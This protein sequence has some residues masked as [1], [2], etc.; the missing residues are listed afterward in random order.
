MFV[1]VDESRLCQVS[2]QTSQV[3]PARNTEDKRC[4]TQPSGRETAWCSDPCCHMRGPRRDVD[5]AWCRWL[6]IPQLRKAKAR[7]LFFS[8]LP[9][10]LVA[11]ADGSLNFPSCSL[12]LYFFL[13]FPPSFHPS[14]HPSFLR[15]VVL[16]FLFFV[17]VFIS[18]ISFLSS[19]HLSLPSWL[20]T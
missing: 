3:K 13:S 18:F 8:Q 15:G 11:G 20:C 2:V 16:S 6:E 4:S 9:S 14:F 10:Q 19:F 7:R 12:F 5:S 1:E 17:F